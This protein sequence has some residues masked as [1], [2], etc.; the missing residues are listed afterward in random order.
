[1]TQQSVLEL[2]K[3]GNPNAI[4]VLI[5]RSLKPKSI[6]AKVNIGDD[7]LIILLESSQVLERKTLVAIIEKYL[8]SLSPKSIRIVKLYG[9]QIGDEYSVWYQDIELG[10]P[11]TLKQYS[12]KQLPDLFYT[13]NEVLRNFN[14]T[15]NNQEYKIEDI[16][17]VS[18]AIIGV[19]LGFLVFITILLLIFFLKMLST[20]LSGFVV[21]TAA[22]LLLYVLSQ[23]QKVKG[24]ELSNYFLDFKKQFLNIKTSS[25]KYNSSNDIVV[26]LTNLKHLFDKGL[27]TEAEFKCKKSEILNNI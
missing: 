7:C 11:H 17:N 1:M 27:I 13:K 22:L 23:H 19:N 24:R 26:K 25:H 20:N 3:Q 21:I 18:K 6:T 4:E 14:K 9:L 5:N 12:S 2:A 8:T 10:K 16:N 15:A